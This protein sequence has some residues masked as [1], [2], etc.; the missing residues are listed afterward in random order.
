[1]IKTNKPIL[2][3]IIKNQEKIYG[4]AID[5]NFSIEEQ[6]VGNYSEAVATRDFEEITKWVELK[7]GMKILDLGCGYGYFVTFLRK[8]GYSAYGCDV[9]EASVEVAKKL[10]EI[11]KLNQNFVVKNNDFKLPYPNEHF[12]FINLN[13]VLVYSKD[14]GR[15][16]KEI[17]R[18]LKKGGKVYLITPN[19]QCC[20]DVNYGLLLIPWLP[21]FFNKFYLRLMGKKDLSF[22]DT[23]NFTTK[24]GME[25][26]FKK[27]KFH[28]G[29]I[30]LKKWHEEIYADKFVG[31]SELYKKIIILVN[32]LKITFFLDRLAN[33]GFYTPLIYLLEK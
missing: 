21:R 30:G 24:R 26:I 20:Y 19:Y 22:F 12:D 15:L 31:R 2:N 10:L 23:F 11:N 28:F 4:G 9:D 14:H 17:K 8:K 25:K 27:F 29:N 16:F 18:I 13:Y 32:K 33:L 1:M 6:V 5:K 3:L 7:K